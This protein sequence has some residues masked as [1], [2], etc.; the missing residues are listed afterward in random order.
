M[1]SSSLKAALL[2]AFLALFASLG[3][4]QPAAVGPVREEPGAT[5]LLT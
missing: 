3:V 2:I 4:A 1:K 5:L